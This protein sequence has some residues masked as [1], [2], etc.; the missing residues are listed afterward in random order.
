[1]KVYMIGAWQHA[2]PCDA[3]P[4]SQLAAAACYKA[5]DEYLRHQFEPATAKLAS[6][7][8]R[9]C[10]ASAT[11]AYRRHLIGRGQRG[12]PSGSTPRECWIPVSAA[13]PLDLLR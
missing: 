5:E 6:S 4:V 8:P 13:A 3:E 12:S 1:M 7:R 9:A 2:C 10:P 11:V